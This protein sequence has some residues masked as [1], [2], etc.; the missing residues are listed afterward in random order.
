MAEHQITVA[1]EQLTLA[2]GA[3]K[4]PRTR[5]RHCRQALG[6]GRQAILKAAQL[7]DEDMLAVQSTLRLAQRASNGFCDTNTLMARLAAIRLDR[8]GFAQLPVIGETKPKRVRTDAAC[9]AIADGDL[10]ENWWDTQKAIEAANAGRYL[11]AGIGVDEAYSVV[12]RH[13]AGD[14]PFLNPQ[15]YKK[16]VETLPPF[17]LNVS[18]GRAFFGAAESIRDGVELPMENGTYHG[19]LVSLRSG[20]SLKFVAT[21]VR[22]GGAVDPFHRLPEFREP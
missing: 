22:K 18:T 4:D 20:R 19:Q 9:L 15:E 17:R 12:L 8:L 5:M 2:I 7:T 14:E 21:L 13:L 10:P 16:I 11:A 6:L 1:C 3:A